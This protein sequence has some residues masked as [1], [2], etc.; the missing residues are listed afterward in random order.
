MDQVGNLYVAESCGN[1]VSKISLTGVI[2]T[3]ATGINY[4]TGMAVDSAGYVYVCNLND[5]SLMKISP[6][7][8]MVTYATGLD[9][10]TD[11]AIQL[12]NVAGSSPM[13]VPRVA[14]AFTFPTP[15]QS[16]VRSNYSGPIFCSIV[17][18]GTTAQVNL[19]GSLSHGIDQQAVTYLWG[20]YD[21]DHF[22]PLS[23][24][25]S[26]PIFNTSIS[27]SKGP[28][29]K[30]LSLRVYSGPEFDEAFF[31]VY[32][33]TVPQTI[34]ILGEITNFCAP[35]KISQRLS[36]QLTALLNGA[37][38]GHPVQNT[39]TVSFLEKYQKLILGLDSSVA[40]DVLAGF[41]TLSQNLIY[42]LEGSAKVTDQPPPILKVT[43]NGRGVIAP[44]LTNSVLQLG[45]VY[46]LLAKPRHASVFTGWSGDIVSS[47]ER[48]TFAATTNLV[49]QA[50]FSS[51]P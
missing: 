6:Q 23:G 17:A 29:E 13:A 8:L 4:P 19:D 25:S 3:F 24:S 2:T 36:A 18:S 28:A 50:N 38:N 16:L 42:A 44:N 12:R 48:I 31:D 37:R 34:G 10:P 45:K 26:S 14:N 15:I 1:T 30:V 39:E 20:D 47:S 49:L 43:I 35:S 40:P 51:P 7:G 46:T 27:I 21:S 9:Y 33:M 22:T 41:E 11:M 5:G 32:A